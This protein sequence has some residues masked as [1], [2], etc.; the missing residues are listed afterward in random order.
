MKR[1]PE[2]AAL[3]RIR[4]MRKLSTDAERLLWKRLRGRQIDGAKFRRQVWLG[5]YIVDFVCL[6]AGLIIEA[7]GGQHV[8]AVEYDERRTVV[9][10][11]PGFTVLRFWNNEVLQNID[12]VVRTIADL[13]AAPSPSHAQAGAGPFLSPSGRGDD[14]PSPTLGEGGVRSAPSAE[15]EGEGA[16]GEAQ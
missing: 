12:G 2:P 5:V 10:A 14:N 11:R 1:P 4:D 13:L 15:R 3:D 8:D 9:M 16:R 7:D 6:D